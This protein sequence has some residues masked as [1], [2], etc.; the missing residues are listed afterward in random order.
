MITFRGHC[1]AS[2][3]VTFYLNCVE[4]AA[5]VCAVANMS[6]GAPLVN[7]SNFGRMASVILPRRTLKEKSIF[8]LFYE[9]KWTRWSC[10]ELGRDGSKSIGK[11]RVRKTC[12]V[13][14]PVYGSFF[15]FFLGGGGEPILRQEKKR[16]ATTEPR[17]RRGAV[18]ARF[19]ARNVSQLTFATLYPLRERHIQRKQKHFS[20]VLRGRLKP[21]VFCLMVFFFAL[22]KPAILLSCILN[23]SLEVSHW[24]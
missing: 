19:I 5:Y 2:A 1:P 6:T 9:N 21:T 14:W 11:T 8:L 18:Y 10:E 22:L 7:R 23:Y 12:E 15:F 24:V 16:S 4:T 13:P 20:M 3:A 17:R